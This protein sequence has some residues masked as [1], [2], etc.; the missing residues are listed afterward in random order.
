MD[1]HPE[2]VLEKVTSKSIPFA[3]IG[4]PIIEDQ[5]SISIYHVGS[6]KCDEQI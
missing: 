5:V 6:C 3:E 2:M 4:D 1:I